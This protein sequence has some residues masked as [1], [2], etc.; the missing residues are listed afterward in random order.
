[1]DG[2]VLAWR[3]PNFVRL[4]LESG[5]Q[6]ARGPDGY[7][8]KDGKDAPAE[9]LAG[10]DNLDSRREIDEL[11]AMCHN[12]AALARAREWKLSRLV[13]LAAAPSELP[14]ALREAAA[15]LEWI[16]LSSPDFQL[17]DAPATSTSIAQGPKE[18]RVRIGLVR[19]DS[20]LPKGAKYEP[21]DL[22]LLAIGE[23]RDGIDIFGTQVLL[24]L[25]PLRTLEREGSAS[26]LRV[27]S[28]MYMR[29]VDPLS[30]IGAFED[31]PSFEIGLAGGSKL[32][33]E[34]PDAEF[35]P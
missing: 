23:Q 35:A 21:G 16:E 28:R 14:R 12:F 8:M 10:R 19:A 32:G 30:P 29:R 27:P 17:L 34:L 33:L 4:A 18:Y 24:K 5:R 15:S 13:P 9:K 3:A 25:D 1:M 11:A 20:K 26:G 31:V 22:Y 2:A 6:Q 7:W